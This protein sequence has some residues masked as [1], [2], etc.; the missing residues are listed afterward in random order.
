MTFESLKA[1][2]AAKGVRLTVK[3]GWFWRAIHW[4]LAIVTLGGNRNFIDGYVTT[5]G[6]VIGV[7]AS[8]E[9]IASESIHARSIIVHE[10]VHV[11]QF[12][13]FGLGSAWL[14]IVPM[15]IC[16]LLLPV[17]MGLAWCRYA[18][19]RSAYLRQAE[20]HRQVGGDP[21]GVISNAVEQLSG[22]SYGWAWPFPS[23]VRR[24]LER[25]FDSSAP[26]E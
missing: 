21:G 2:L 13:V 1:Q 19:E 23:R 9:R 3:R 7:P 15:G 14:G 17:P 24:W 16:Y 5:I 4:A 10:L 20:Y 12:R 26:E 11:R 8:W 6:P 18:L 25:K 22:P